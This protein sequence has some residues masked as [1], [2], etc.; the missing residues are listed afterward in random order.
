MIKHFNNWVVDFDKQEFRK[1]KVKP[2]K[3][4]AFVVVKF[5]SEEGKILSDKFHKSLFK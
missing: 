5:Q 2:S 1:K 3:K 4:G